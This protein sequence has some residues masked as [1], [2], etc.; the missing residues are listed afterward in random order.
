MDATWEAMRHVMKKDRALTTL[1]N[2]YRWLKLVGGIATAVVA[3]FLA[4]STII[5][6]AIIQIYLSNS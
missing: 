5:G 1:E 2:V 6:T 4:T 3:I